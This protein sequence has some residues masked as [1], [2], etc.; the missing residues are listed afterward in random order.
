MTT[1]QK[2]QAMIDFLFEEIRFRDNYGEDGLTPRQRLAY[3]C[4]Y[5]R[6]GEFLYDSRDKLTWTPTTYYEDYE[7]ELRELVEKYNKMSSGRLEV[8]VANNQ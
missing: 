2:L 4:Y 7:R 8:E 6:A 3:Q 5:G 1:E